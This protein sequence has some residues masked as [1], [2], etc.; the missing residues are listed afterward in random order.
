VQQDA[1]AALDW[2]IQQAWSNGRV[3]SFGCSALG[4]TQFALAKAAHPALQA[5]LVSGAGGA[6]GSL[7]GRHGYFG[8]FEGGIFQLA[9]GYGWLARRGWLTPPF[10]RE[11]YS[12]PDD[13]QAVLQSL[14]R[15]PVTSQI[16]NANNAGNAWHFITRTPLQDPAWR[17]LNYI[18]DDDAINI[19]TLTINTWNDQTVSESILL[20]EHIASPDKRLI[21]APGDHCNHEQQTAPGKSDWQSVYNQW[22]DQWLRPQAKNAGNNADPHL[23]PVSYRLPDD[24]EWRHAKQ[25]PPESSRAVSWYL[26]SATSANSVFGDGRLALTPDKAVQTAAFSQWRADPADP[27]PSVGGPVCCTST[28]TITSGHQNQQTVEQRQDVLVFSSEPFSE[29]TA[30]AGPV[31]ASL[32]L[33]SDASDAD[34]I[35]R[36]T[37]VAPDGTS[38]NI[39]EGAQRVSLAAPMTSANLANGDVVPV[40]VTVRDMAHRFLPGHRLRV[41]V[42]ASSFPRLARN[43]QTGGFNRANTTAFIANHRLHHSRRYPSQITLTQL[44]GTD[45]DR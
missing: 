28:P 19:P 15:L 41:Q 35:V 10:V 27:V 25:W 39:Q 13:A 45:K 23:P 14:A 11:V 7:A 40:T 43:L 30:F 4:E 44:T 38:V 8:L 1:S 33:S 21:L 42:A 31:R 32:Y 17:A 3:G 34:L 26:Q 9:S 16:E 18:H 37:D 5:M 29:A 12:K 36:I 2:I 20:H 6:M 22:F 24:T